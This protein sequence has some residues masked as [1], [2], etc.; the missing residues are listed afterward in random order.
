M[1]ETC[2][3]FEKV[4]L[5]FEDNELRA[6]RGRGPTSTVEVFVC[7]HKHSP[8][9]R[10]SMGGLK[11]KCNGDMGNCQVSEEKFLDMD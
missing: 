10:V 3:F 1:T 5:Q 4:V 8:V 9:S 6:D 2:T 11:L 7:T